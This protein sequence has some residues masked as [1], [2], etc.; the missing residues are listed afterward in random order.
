MRKSIINIV[1]DFTGYDETVV[2]DIACKAPTT[3]KR[4]RIPKK[5]GL[6]SRVI[7]HPTPLTKSIQYALI[8]TLLCKL[9]VHECAIAY[10]SRQSKPQSISSPILRNAQI[11]AIDCD[12]IPA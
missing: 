7:Y 5:S 12:K 3:Y 2:H 4:Y 9:P 10:Q 6:G 1:A 8:S 11:H